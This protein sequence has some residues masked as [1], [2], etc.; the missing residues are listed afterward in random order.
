MI[1]Q[2]YF[3]RE[4]FAFSKVISQL[5]ITIASLVSCYPI[6]GTLGN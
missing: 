5:V 1:K 6:Y 2:I 4:V 3:P